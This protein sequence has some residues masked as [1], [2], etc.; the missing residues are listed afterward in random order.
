M[1]GLGRKT[2]KACIDVEGW[3]LKAG[4]YVLLLLCSKKLRCDVSCLDSV[5]LVLALKQ[6]GGSMG[7]KA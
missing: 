5:V 2:A 7:S 1:C 4:S 3:V 6:L